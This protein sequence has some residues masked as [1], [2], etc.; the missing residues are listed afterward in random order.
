MRVH[1]PMASSAYWAS[2]NT[3]Y[4]TKLINVFLCSPTSLVKAWP[5][6]WW[7]SSW[8]FPI[9]LIWLCICYHSKESWKFGN[10]NYMNN[11][12]V[13]PWIRNNLFFLSYHSSCLMFESL[14]CDM[15]VVQ[16]HLHVSTPHTHMHT[17]SN[18]N[19]LASFSDLNKMYN[20]D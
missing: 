3:K 8:S 5:C 15:W 11:V 1:Q 14:F 2:Y 7:I 4:N 12:I 6:S 9:T 13:V 20:W 16:L 10:Y 17:R 19:L 18:S